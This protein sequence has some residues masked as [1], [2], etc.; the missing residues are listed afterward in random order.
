MG[1]IQNTEI[2]APTIK[3]FLERQDKNIWEFR[4]F[5][6]DNPEVYEEFEERCL[7]IIEA[8]FKHYGAR[9]IWEEMRW[10]FLPANGKFKYRDGQKSFKLQNNH[11]PYYAKMFIEDHPQHK[12]FFM[13]RAGV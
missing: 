11:C 10:H 7:D 9:A 1:L 5:H 8:D 6:K 12:G 13:I 3:E 2:P 4:A